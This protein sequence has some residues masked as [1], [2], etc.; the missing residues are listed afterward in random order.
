MSST[1]QAE[2]AFP[3]SPP[4]SMCFSVS[5]FHSEILHVALHGFDYFSVEHASSFYD[6]AKIFFVSQLS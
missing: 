5:Q 2:P 3:H 4:S 1:L 6:N